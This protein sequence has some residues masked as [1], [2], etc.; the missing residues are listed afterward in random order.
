METTKKKDFVELSYTGYSNGNVFDSNIAE[1]LKKIDSKAKPKKTIVIIGEGMVVPGLDKALEGNE[2][3]K[4]YEVNLTAKEGFGE[5]D[6]TL[7]KTIPLKVFTEK[8]INPRAGMVLALDDML[9]KIVAVSGAR[10]ITDFNNPLAGKDLT[11]KYKI[12][13]ILTDEKEKASSLLEALFRFTPEF[14]VNDKELIVKGAKTLEVFVTAF[15][16]KIKEILGKEAKFEEK[17]EEKKEAKENKVEKEA[18][19][20]KENSGKKV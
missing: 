8:N 3:G 7:L 16:D 6:R 5:R 9:A 1:D 15:K 10:V 18:K 12:L 17:I 11:Y 19:E 20:V 13:K 4:D 2:V 14:D